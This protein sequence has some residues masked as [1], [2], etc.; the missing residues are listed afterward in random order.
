MTTRR[1]FLS[2]AAAA[3]SGFALSNCG[4]RL[5]DVRPHSG[6][7]GR[8]DRLYIYTWE[9]YTDQDLFRDF[10]AQTGIKAIAMI[11]DS[12]EVMLGRIQA[13]GGGD[14]SIIYPSD[15]MVQQM[16]ELGLLAELNHDRLEGLNRLFPRFQDGSY[17]PGNRHSIPVSWGT[18]G[19]IYNRR[20]LGTDPTD[21]GF[22]WDNRDRLKRK[23]TLLNDVREVMGATLKM[24]GHSYNTTQPEAIRAAYEALQT[25]KP[26]LASFT[27]DAWRTQI[28]T[29][30]LDIAMCYSSDANAIM[31]EN[32][33]LAYV[34]PSSGSSLWV[35]TAVI[36]ITAKNI[37]GAYQWLNLLLE[38]Q[39][40]AG[41][42]ERLSFATPNQEA[43]GL[44]SPALRQDSSLF[45]A[46][47]A[48]AHCEG[49]RPVGTEISE[50][51]DRYWTLL[52][53]G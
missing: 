30:D 46:E 33:D 44:L 2:T 15:Y 6:G 14:Y 24:L 31:A 41:L 53:S 11:Y 36:P 34:L 37:D 35:D 20:T 21:W 40:S 3:C 51:F 45:P 49:I 12:N 43:Y 52:T 19:L 1:Q 18:T 28:L 42:T 8:S 38:P 5:A 29:G 17:D 39:V 10:E 48:L 25:L 13:Q 26:Y 4:W 7:A 22:L 50:L 9:G 27:S 23:I 47:G 16:V 32:P